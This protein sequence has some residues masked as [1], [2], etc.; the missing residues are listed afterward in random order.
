VQF[1]PVEADLLYFATDLRSLTDA[2]PLVLVEVKDTGQPPDAGTGQ[3]KGY[4]YWVKPAY[5]VITNG[6]VLRCLQLP[7]RR[8]PGREGP[9]DQSIRSA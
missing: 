2:D 7:G 3:A 5:Y 9:R 1:R 4:A 8:C 6:D